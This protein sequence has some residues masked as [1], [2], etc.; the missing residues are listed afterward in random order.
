MDDKS[1]ICREAKTESCGSFV[2][3]S[4]VAIINPVNYR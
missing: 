3:D 4:R 1:Q 2:E